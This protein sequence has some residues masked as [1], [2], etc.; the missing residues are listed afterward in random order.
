MHS[1]E[2][3]YLNAHKKIGKKI[4]HYWLSALKYQMKIDYLSRFLYFH[5]KTSFYK[6][7][8]VIINILAFFYSN[9]FGICQRT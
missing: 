6:N 4:N 2:T 3:I 9:A 1:A 7:N 5:W 8:K